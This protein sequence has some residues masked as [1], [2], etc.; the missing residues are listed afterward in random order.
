MNAETWQI[1][2][3]TVLMAATA[4]VCVLPPAVAV[5]WLLA[6][7]QFAGKALLETVV[8]LPLVLPPVASGLLAGTMR[9]SLLASGEVD[10][11]VAPSTAQP[12]STRSPAPAVR[13]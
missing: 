8:S 3:F 9:E 6:R 5:G 2:R 10:V 12:G 7:R 1:A 4:T 13:R 11:V